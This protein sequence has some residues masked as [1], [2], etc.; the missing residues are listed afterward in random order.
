MLALLK[1]EFALCLHP[2][3]LLFLCFAA[4]V[5]IPSYPYE[6]MFF[7]S[8]LSVFFVCLTA[9]ENGDAAYTCCMPVK[10]RQVAC[11]RILMC[12]LLQLALLTLAAGT[13][14][15]KELCFPPEK[16]INMAGMMANTAF[17]G[18]GAV[19]LG[20]F[21]CIFFPVYYRDPQKVG[22]PFV[23]AAVAV[24][25]VIILLVVLRFGVPFFRDTLNTP[26][27]ENF[28]LKC[29][30]LGIGLAFYTLCTTFAVCRGAKLFERGDL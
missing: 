27:P 9:R 23:F 25:L 11:A 17:L 5:F 24:F 22:K 10:K 8:G 19:V 16:Q 14:A 18:F 1:K 13:T 3:C 12:V 29:A 15:V 2:T 21:N 7:F 30:V 4:F 26:D 20:V 28:G 6:V